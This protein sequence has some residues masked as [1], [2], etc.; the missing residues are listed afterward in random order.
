MSE[1]TGETG[2]DHRDADRARERETGE[3][4]RREGGREVERESGDKR[5][6][7]RNEMER[8]YTERTGYIH[9]PRK[10]F[11]RIIRWF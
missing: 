8:E 6:G 9:A 2:R 4:N 5:A 3:W 1:S 11:N 7:K 10:C